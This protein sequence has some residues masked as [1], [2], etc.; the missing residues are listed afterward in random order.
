MSNKFKNISPY[1]VVEIGQLLKGPLEIDWLVS[2][3][4]PPN[5]TTI[6]AGESG[7]GKTWLL[8]DLILSIASGEK[9]LGRFEVSPGPVLVIDEE[10]A[11]LLLR[12]RLNQL[13]KARNFNYD[14]EDLPI[15]FVI[16]QMA[17]LSPDRDRQGN[18]MP[19]EPFKRIYRTIQECN[20]VLTTFDSLTRVHRHNE[21]YAGDMALVF[22]QVK[23]LM[24]ELKTACL[25]T[26]HFT[27]SG[28]NGDGA[29]IRGSGDIRAFADTTILA[30]QGK[31]W[32]TVTHDKSRWAK[33]IAPFGVKVEVDKKSGSVA[34]VYDA[35][36]T[37]DDYRD[38]WTWLRDYLAHHGATSR[39]QLIDIATSVNVCKQRTLDD[40]FN[41]RVEK[42]YLTKE[43][44]G[45]E[46][47]YILPN[48]EIKN[49]DKDFIDE[50][51][52]FRQATM[53]AN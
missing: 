20:P 46:M 36:N 28:R 49:A 21:M 24:D 47:F 30:E 8:L 5:T 41:W 18:V 43:R 34:I 44:R 39:Q 45:R 32:I 17:H 26:H 48:S 22:S 13:I 25:F 38:V 37:R 10:N 12:I 4:I 6:L 14:V 19:S 40:T 50:M 2:G 52:E 33:P 23:M 3:L 16:G 1:G 42:G 35:E 27:K 53:L 31:D 29:R 15:F 9:W 7:V 11:D 51:A